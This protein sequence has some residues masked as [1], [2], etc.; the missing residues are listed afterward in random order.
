MERFDIRASGPD[1]QAGAL[2][3][4]NQQKVVLARELAETPSVIVCCY[5]TRGLDFR[6]SEWLHNEIR[7]RRDQ[8]CAAIVYASVDLEELLALCDRVAVMHAGEIVGVVPA[9][10]ATAEAIGMMMGGVRPAD[11]QR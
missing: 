7:Q 9:A 11:G 5:A 8:G 2:S 4:G 10:T 1:T 3:G 6:S